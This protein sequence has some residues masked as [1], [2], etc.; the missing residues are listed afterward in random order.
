MTKT[1]PTQENVDALKQAA[2]LA[3]IEGDQAHAK[4]LRK[5]ALFEQRRLREHRSG[6]A[7]VSLFM[8]DA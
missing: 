2:Y 6:C 7:G 5:A 8:E 3:D 4:A 1:T